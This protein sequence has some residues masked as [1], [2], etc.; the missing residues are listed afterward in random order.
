MSPKL[1]WDDQISVD[2]EVF[3]KRWLND[4]QHI[5]KIKIPRC[6]ISSSVRFESL[7]KRELHH[8][9]DASQKRY[10]TVTYLLMVAP[11]DC[12]MRNFV[13][14]KARLAPLKSVSI[15]RLELVAAALAAR[16]DSMLRCELPTVMAKS[17]FCTDSLAVLFMVKNSTKRFPVFVGNRLSQI[18]EIS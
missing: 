16:V 4:L 7:V 13:F 9:A 3:W 18:E 6:F 1:N 2:E 17:V 8:F 15:P 12:I 11:I 14:G 5:Q 10:G